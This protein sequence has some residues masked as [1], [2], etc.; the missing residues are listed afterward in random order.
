LPLSFI[1]KDLKNFNINLSDTHTVGSFAA[2]ASE[3]NEV[4]VG[5]DTRK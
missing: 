2:K 3:D 1:P 4:C 5:K